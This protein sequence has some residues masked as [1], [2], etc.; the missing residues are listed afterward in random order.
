MTNNKPAP[1]QM[2]ITESQAYR[3]MSEILMKKGNLEGAFVSASRAVELHGSESN[4]KW[5]LSVASKKGV[6]K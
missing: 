6:L 5:E 2:A 1:K 4:I 3:R